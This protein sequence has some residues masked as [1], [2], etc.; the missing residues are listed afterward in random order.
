MLL[1]MKASQF[2]PVALTILLLACAGC[3]REPGPPVAKVLRKTIE[4]HGCVWTDN[5]PSVRFQGLTGRHEDRVH[6]H[7]G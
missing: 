5:Y 2:T 1:L 4:K 7:P 6:C 3:H